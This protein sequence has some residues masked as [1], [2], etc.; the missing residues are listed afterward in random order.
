MSERPIKRPPHQQE[1]SQSPLWFAIAGLVI[2]VLSFGMKDLM[3]GD[4]VFWFG[5]VFAAVA[6]LYYFLQPKH[7]MPS[8]R[9]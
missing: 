3:I 1:R 2:S 4:V 9:K 8:G 7:G 6:L 5:G